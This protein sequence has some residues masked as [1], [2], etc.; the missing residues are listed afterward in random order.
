MR[1]GLLWA[2]VVLTSLLPVAAR[3]NAQA[4]ET[5]ANLQFTMDT[6]AEFREVRKTRL[7]RTAKTQTGTLSLSSS[8]IL[9]MSITAPRPEERRL[10]NTT[11]SLTRHGKTRSTPLDENRGAHQLLLT[12]VDV[13]QGN[14]PRLQARFSIEP[15]E[16]APPLNAGKPARQTVDNWGWILIPKDPALNS[17]LSSLILRGTGTHLL[18]VRAEQ[19]ESFQEITL[20][21][22][23]SQA[24]LFHSELPDTESPHRQVPSLNEPFSGDMP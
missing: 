16:P 10:S 11:L 23:L 2:A 9:L 17:E 19:G 1:A 8:G 4:W 13:L 14:M 18:S 24:E 5:I 22:A 15:Y 12:I 6:P 3:A 21:S 7:Q 20:L